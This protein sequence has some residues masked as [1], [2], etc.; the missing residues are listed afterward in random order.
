MKKLKNYRV[1]YID[2]DL[3]CYGW[4]YIPDVKDEEEAMQKFILKHIVKNSE[5]V[6]LEECE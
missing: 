5:L 2:H 1:K 3:K 6:K 4:D